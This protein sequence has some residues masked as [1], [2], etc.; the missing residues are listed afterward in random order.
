[1][2]CW[3]PTTTTVCTLMGTRTGIKTFAADTGVS[4]TLRP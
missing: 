3:T 4:D 2:S 1:M